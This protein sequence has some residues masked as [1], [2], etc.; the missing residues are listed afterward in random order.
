MFIKICSK[1]FIKSTYSNAYRL[2]FLKN[3]AA[4]NKNLGEKPHI[5]EQ[6]LSAFSR[7][8]HLI[9][10]KRF[11]HGFLLK[12]RFYKVNSNFQENNVLRWEITSAKRYLSNQCTSVFTLHSSK[13]FF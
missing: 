3:Y 5:C 10:H 4:W 9:S 2:L 11:C 1:R 13:I 7:N 6:C 8:E 12:Y